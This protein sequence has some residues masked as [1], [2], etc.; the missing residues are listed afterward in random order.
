M[1]VHRKAVFSRQGLLSSFA[2]ALS[3]VAC[4]SPDSPPTSSVDVDQVEVVRGVADRGQDPAVVAIDIGEREL[5]TGALVAPGVVLTARHCVAQTS[6][7]V[8]CPP[9]G[10]QVG[11]A[12]RPDSLAIMVGDAIATAKVRAHGAEIV[13]PSGDV[14]CGAD[15]AL[16]VLDQPIDD[17]E[18]LAV[19]AHGVA[20]GDRVRAVG[21]GR[22]HDGAPAGVKLL[23]DHVLV[24]DTTDT[25][26]FVGQAT[27]QGDSGGPA[28]DESTGEI[29]GVV[30]R[31][32]PSCDSSGAHNVYTRA[33]AFR[34]L[35]D[36]AIAKAARHAGPMHGH[37]DA[38]KHKPSSD[39]GATCQHGSDCAAGVCVTAG[40]KRYCS[41]ACD[42]QD[43][44]P[45]HFA[46]RATRGGRVCVEH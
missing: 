41:R 30:S 27:C 18:P 2:V 6:E 40:A 38:G 7:S 4:S 12:R 43:K 19:R 16:V 23:R 9:S 15:V 39:L 21:F 10:R 20:K 36:D 11:A 26:F 1:N 37:R 35:V 34:A 17:V 42:P 33:D 24:L 29:V 13:A 22:A 3:L 5:C 31:G 28:L 32:G 46:C 44:C 14:L 8:A 45:T 25:E